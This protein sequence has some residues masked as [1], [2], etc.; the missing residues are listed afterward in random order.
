M[1]IAGNS[2]PASGSEH[3]ISHQLDVMSNE[4]GLKPGAHGA[5]VGLASI[6]MMYLHKGNWQKI[7][8]LLID[9]KSPTTIEDLGIDREFF[10]NAVLHASEIRPERY[11]ILSM[12]ITR[13]RV[14]EAL[15]ATGVG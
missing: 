2:R 10:I 11:T 13:G 14:E 4:Q 3:L 1:S 7:K 12:G 8:N 6:V 15:E 9:I 5:Q